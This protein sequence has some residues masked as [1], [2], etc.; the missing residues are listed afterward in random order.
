MRCSRS[1]AP[2]SRARISGLVVTPATTPQA[3]MSRISFSS[4]LSRKNMR[5][6]CASPGFC[7]GGWA[8]ETTF[9]PLQIVLCRDPLTFAILRAVATTDLLRSIPM[10]EGLT[11]DDLEHLSHNL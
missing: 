10:F 5:S 8:Q 11:P 9:Y 6:S 7:P 1:A 2:A 3:K 4:E